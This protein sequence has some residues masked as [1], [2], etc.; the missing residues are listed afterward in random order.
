MPKN[1]FI[2]GGGA[3]CARKIKGY[4]ERNEIEVKG[5]LINREYIKEDLKELYGIP[6]YVLEDFLVHN[7]CIIIVA[8]AGYYEGQLK[9]Y[10]GNIEKLYA[11]DFI[12][13]LCLEEIDGTI[14]PEFYTKNKKNLEWL[15]N[16]L[17]DEKSKKALNDYIFQKM[18]GIYRKDNYEL[19]QYFPNDVIHFQ[20]Q[21][22][23]VDCGAY[24]GESA[25]DFINHLETQ[26]IH[27]YKKI[28]SIEAEKSN[29][30]RLEE[31]LK[32]YANVEIIF[33]GV[34]NE[35]NILRINS[36][37]GD[38]SSISD[39]GTECVEMKAIDDIL[40]GE[41]ATYIKMDIEG[42]E[43]HALYGAA[44][45]IKK[46]KPKLAICIYHKPEDL[47]QIPQFIYQLREDYQFYIRNHSPYG[48]EA[49][50]YAI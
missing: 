6:V 12:G 35:T 11:L 30:L 9:E 4:C 38:N 23:F 10:A 7:K 8:F 15:E 31:H 49:V 42:S 17:A 18:S 20:E 41:A 39:K 50:L 46:Y 2:S 40:K 19:N 43:L 36:G 34:W 22:I 32:N 24:Q 45:T 25:I 37:Y 3:Q 29:F 13:K 21:E 14:T 28:I 16:K 48:I 44:G 5:F 1:Q 27:S 47:I 33:A 26:G